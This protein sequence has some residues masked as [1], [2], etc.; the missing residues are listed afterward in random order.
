MVYK[1]ARQIFKLMTR[2]YVCATGTELYVCATGTELYV[3]ATG[4]EL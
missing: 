3:C 4:T 2:L 1:E